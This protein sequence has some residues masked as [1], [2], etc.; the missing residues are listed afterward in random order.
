MTNRQISL[1]TFGAAAALWTCAA[2]GPYPQARTSPA[3][4][5]PATFQ[6]AWVNPVQTP[7]TANP[8]ADNI[9]VDQRMKQAF[10]GALSEKGFQLK[11]DPNSATYLASY[12]I[13][14]Q[15]EKDADPLASH[16]F[17]SMDGCVGGHGPIDATRAQLKFELVDKATGRPAWQASMTK[18]VSKRAASQKYLNKVASAMTANLP[19]AR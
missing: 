17:C 16:S 5:A 7:R 2:A 14:M 8:R 18:V 3:V 13:Q 15:D 10:D 6:Y 12:E 19:P 9:T 11:S 1:A 4:A